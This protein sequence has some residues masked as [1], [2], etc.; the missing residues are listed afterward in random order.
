MKITDGW[1]FR[2]ADFSVQA[3]GKSNTGKVLLIRNAAEKERWHKMS[4]ADKDDEN[5]PPLF[6][7]AEGVDVLDAINY[8]NYLAKNAKPIE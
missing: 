8:A 3:A 7:E 5:G 1:A 2:S 4:D 6:I